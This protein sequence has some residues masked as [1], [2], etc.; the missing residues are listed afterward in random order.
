M[1]TNKSFYG[2]ITQIEN[3]PPKVQQQLLCGLDPAQ[4]NEEENI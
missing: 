2:K 4:S 3:Y 1:C